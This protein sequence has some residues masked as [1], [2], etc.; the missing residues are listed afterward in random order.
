VH[1]L[2]RVS[3]SVRYLLEKLYDPRAWLLLVP[4]LTVLTVAAWFRRDRREAAVV[5]AVIVLCLATL[6]LAYWTSQFE[7]HYHLATSARRVITGP[8]LAWSFL[9][10]LL[11]GRGYSRAT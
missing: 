8:I 6:V 4:L 11:W 7:I 1:R 5:A 3:T 2:G 9:V 10:P